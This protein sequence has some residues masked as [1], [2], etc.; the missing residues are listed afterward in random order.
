MTPAR[1]PLDYPGGEA[2]PGLAAFYLAPWLRLA[3]KRG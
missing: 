1:L 3:G 2:P